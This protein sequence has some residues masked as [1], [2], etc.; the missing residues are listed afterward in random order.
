MPKEN[1]RAYL[2]WAAICLI[3]GT[4]YL[5]IRIG[6]KDFPPALFA[7]FRWF[8]AGPILIF[9]LKMRGYKLPEFKDIKH[10][11]V[12]GL[13]LL[14]CGNGL[15]VFAEQ[16]LP[17]GIAAL[18]I[19]TMPFWIV[20]LESFLPE[21]PK[22]NWKIIV[23]LVMGLS[24]VVLIFGV[25]FSVLFNSDYLT[26]IIALMIGVF[27]WSSGTLYSKY[28][29]VSVHPL[30]GASVQMT[31]A[32]TALTMLGLIL[33]EGS[34]LHFTQNGT[35][36]FIY[37]LIFGSFIAYGAY[38][39]AVANLPVSFVSTYAYINPVIALFLGWIVLDE[40]MNLNIIIAA[41]IILTGVYIVKKGTSSK[42]K[43][44][45]V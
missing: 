41:V 29:K 2:A 28:K 37:L 35:L 42:I 22:I 15:V 30:M 19:T 27:C 21:G 11:A 1:L 25:D 32:G 24:G 6:V 43:M 8:I 5:A 39:Y 7:G 14:G 17:S 23:G 3:W 40:A 18:L 16:W 34:R 44:R 4:T 9:I 38:I 45:G 31:I 26:G 20:G 36:A 33:G 10:L 13:L 12:V